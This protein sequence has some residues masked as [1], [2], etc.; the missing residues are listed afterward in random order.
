MRRRARES[1]LQALYQLDV[2]GLLPRGPVSNPVDP[3]RVAQAIERFWRSFKP[4]KSDERAYA[5]RLIQGV[6]REVQDLDNAIAAISERWRVERMEAVSRNLL[7]L[8]AYELL[9]C[10]D[11]PRSVS[12]NEAVE[13]AKRFS[14]PEAA[15]FVNGVLDR[16]ELDDAR[17]AEETPDA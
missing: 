5:E 1:A 13:I 15:A 11:V 12:I 8:A 17:D 2:A 3:V 9:H 6:T 7:R 16:L 14:G 4:V 10:P